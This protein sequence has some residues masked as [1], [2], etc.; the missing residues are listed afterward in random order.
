MHFTCRSFLGHPSDTSWSQFW[1]MEPDDLSL[2]SRR[3]HLFGLINI[4]TPDSS[5]NQQGR[6]LINQI[7]EEYYSSTE[8]GISAQLKNTL[9]SISQA[10]LSIILAVINGDQLHLAVLN[11]GHCVLQRRQQI[12]SLLVGAEDSIVN[13][14]GQISDSDRLLLCTDSFYQ[15]FSW[16]KIKS[17]LSS[18][19]LDNV[20]ENF[21]SRLYS[22]EHQSLLAGA[23]IEIHEESTPSI[24]PEDSLEAPLSRGAVRR[25][26]GFEED[27]K[28]LKS[29]SLFSIFHRSQSSFVAH[30]D[31]P[32]ITRRKRTNLLLASVILIALFVSVIFGYRRN[33]TL[34]S[35]KQYQSLKSA[36]K[37]KI[38][39]AQTLKSLSLSDALVQAKEAQTILQK[40][41]PYS[42]TH[43]GE[44]K[45]FQDNVNG[46]LSQT[47][48]S[49]SFVPQ[50]FFDITLIG[51]GLSYTQMSLQ[52]NNLYLFDPVTG[53]IDKLDISHKSYQNVITSADLKSS[54]LIGENNSL[55]YLL[56]DTHVLAVQGQTVTPK[57][58]L[59]D[60]IKDFSTGQLRFWNSSLYVL[61]TGSSVPS[62]WKYPPNAAG[63]SDGT[64][65]LKKPDLSPGPSSL[66]INGDIW[67]ISRTGIIT[68]YNLGVKKDFK[69]VVPS[70]LTAAGNLVTS[71]DSNVLAFTDQDSRVFVYNKTGQSTGE[72]N[73]GSLKISSLAYDP[74]S[75]TIFVL[76]TDKKI[77]KIGL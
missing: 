67:V 51:N 50:S 31:S 23:L 75:N 25:T 38:N 33:L 56:K 40:M 14:S 74:A 13:I 18:D 4:T 77:Y 60:Q 64:N 48:S 2:V 69:Q 47:G 22:L 37:I 28:G 26:E 44:I 29:K 10:N 71:L 9:A 76:C 46:L 8:T 61:T 57:I 17:S 35:E 1:E 73:F 12:S 62:I 3:G 42:P 59:T 11:S 27:S 16:E 5:A 43:V 21:L 70:G 36:L 6:Q 52:G 15:D 65:W 66:A 39:N 45:T 41:S 68:P 19:N 63:F 54:Q 72:Y 32:T 49:D 53:R 34:E 20:E 55:L 7:N 30:V 24:I 58:N